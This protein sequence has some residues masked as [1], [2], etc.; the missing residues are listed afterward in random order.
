M[1]TIFV[2]T[3][4]LF[5]RQ[6]KEADLRPMV[7]MFADPLTIEFLTA[8]RRSP[9]EADIWRGMA[10][11]EGHRVLRGFSFFAVEEKSTG[12]FV[13]R[14]GPLRPEGWPDL[15]VGWGLHPA[16]RG[17]G[18]AVEAARASLDWSIARFGT[19]ERIIHLIRPENTFSA[20]VAKSLGAKTTDKWRLPSGDECMI[21]ESRRDPAE[22]RNR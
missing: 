3:K 19:Q 4:R 11:T 12:A 5:L 18:Y 21:W 22:G 9:P 1:T 14:V 17:K 8:E 6:F 7:E 16:H 2:E 20:N 15:E 10:F 13:G